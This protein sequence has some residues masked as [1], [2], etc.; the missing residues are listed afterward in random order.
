MNRR[1]S[2]WVLIGIIVACWWAVFAVVAGPGHNLGP[3]I[4]VEITAP[5]SVL[6]RRMSLGVF[7]FILLNGVFYAV[8]GF[9]VELVGMCVRRAGRSGA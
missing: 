9:A 2:L 8:I 3:S 4:F 6:G 7:W 1:I 5:A